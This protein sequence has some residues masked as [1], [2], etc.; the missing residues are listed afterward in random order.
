MFT[1]IITERWQKK[2]KELCIYDLAD[3]IGVVD[4]MN[5]CQYA[6]PFSSWI[7]EQDIDRMHHFGRI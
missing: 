2:V 3:Y 5:D 6:F 1:G 4:E 7:I